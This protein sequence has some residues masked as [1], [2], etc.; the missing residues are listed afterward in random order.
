MNKVEQARHKLSRAVIQLLAT[1]RLAGE[2]IITISRE[3]IAGNEFILELRW[4]DNQ[5]MLVGQSG[6]IN[7]I[8]MDELVNL[9]HHQALHIIWRH[10]LRYADAFD[11]ELVSV[12]CDIAVNQYLDNA[13]AGTMTLEEVEQLIRQS[14]LPK[15]DSGY[16]LTKL[17]M[18]DVSQKQSVV[19]AVKQHQQSTDEHRP[20]HQGW[21][22][23]G[24]QL[25]R[26]G[27][28]QQALQQSTSQLTEKQ[29]GL[30]PQ[31][32]QA[33]LSPVTKHYRVPLHRALWQLL[34]Q[35]PRGYEPS[36]AR[37]NRRQPLRLELPGR[38]TKLVSYLYVFID[39][40]G[41]MSNE[42][43]A[44]V[45]Q[46]LNDLAQRATIEMMVGTFDAAIQSPPKLVN[47]GHPLPLERHGGGGTSYQ[48]VFDY[49]Y[50]Q[51]IHR[52]TPVVIVTDGWGESSIDNHGY[53]RVLWLLTRD[54]DLSVQNISAFTTRLEVQP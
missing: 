4:R 40:S 22:H 5:L 20:L 2:I 27:H 48:A 19:N 11:R 34:G 32:I 9:L 30:L 52:Q 46:M 47:S 21:F 51:H 45:I 18:L 41:S 33:A 36:Q 37:F 13:P 29:R 28:L 44:A 49:L 7:K 15:Q 17:R 6:L 25:I 14:L 8:R 26:R 10:P 42:T 43:I 24:N 38:I 12:A 54:G 39:Q 16:Y 23:P 35:V 3:I 1:D 31:A 50:Q 53:Q